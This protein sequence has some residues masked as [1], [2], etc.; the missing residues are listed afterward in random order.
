[1]KKSELY[2]IIGSAL[3]CGTVLLLLFLIV[4]PGQPTPED[5]GII[6]SFGNSFDG[7]SVRTPVP[8]RTAQPQPS[9]TPPPAERQQP[10]QQEKVLTQ[11]DPSPAISSQTEEEKKLAEERRKQEE[12]ERIAEE[13]RRREEEE[14]RIAEEKRKKQEAIEKANAMG[15][16]FGNVMTPEGSGQ[17]EGNAQQGNPVGQGSSEGHSWSL[18]GRALMGKLANPSDTQNVEG[19]VTVSIRVDEN[20]NVISASISRPTDISDAKTQKA[21]LEAARK[22]KFSAGKNIAVGTITYNIKLR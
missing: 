8:G 10:Q 5:E 20:G 9:T 21:A 18:A 22:T 3:F 11:D 17:S 15:N 16:V 13:K 1:M 7:G 4:M 6:V 19:R 12:A 2:G 14:R